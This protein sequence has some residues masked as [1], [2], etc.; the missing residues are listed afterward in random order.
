MSVQILISAIGVDHVKT[1]YTGIDVN[2][3]DMLQEQTV[4]YTMSVAK[5]QM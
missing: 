3:A 5:A 4:N 2:A 1:K